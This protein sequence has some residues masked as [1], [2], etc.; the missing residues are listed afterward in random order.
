MSRLLDNQFPLDIDANQYYQCLEVSDFNKLFMNP[1]FIEE[2]FGETIKVTVG[3]SSRL[4]KRTIVENPE[5]VKIISNPSK[6]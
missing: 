6:A 3:F 2:S 4:I 1:N 5:K